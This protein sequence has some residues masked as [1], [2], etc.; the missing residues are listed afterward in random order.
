MVVECVAVI[1]VICMTAYFY[2]IAKKPNIAFSICPLSFVPVLYL[3]GTGLSGFF[4]KNF[5]FE[6]IPTISFF[7]LIGAVSACSLFGYFSSK[8]RKKSSKM[9]YNIFC[10]GFTVIFA[11]VLIMKMI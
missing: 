6:T 9:F 3:I 8:L 5:G 2:F 11:W 10:I 4:E 1:I 7:V